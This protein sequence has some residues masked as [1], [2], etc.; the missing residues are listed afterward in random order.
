MGNTTSEIF[1]E[2]LRR[3]SDIEEILMT[4]R[5]AGYSKIT[6]IKALVDPGYAG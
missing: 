2:M 5:S 6:S 4:L 3:G 1:V